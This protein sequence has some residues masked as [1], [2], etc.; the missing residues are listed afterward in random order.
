MQ[1]SLL[2]VILAGELERLGYRSVSM[3]AQQK[4]SKNKNNFPF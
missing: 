2:G 1:I 4:R 3:S